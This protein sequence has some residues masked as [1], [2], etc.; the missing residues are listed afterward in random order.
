[1]PIEEVEDYVPSPATMELAQPPK[2]GTDYEPASKTSL[3]PDQKFDDAQQ[4]RVRNNLEQEPRPRSDV[5]VDYELLLPGECAG[6]ICLN[7]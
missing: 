5:N 2:A 3:P 1:M 7:P 6:I 4:S